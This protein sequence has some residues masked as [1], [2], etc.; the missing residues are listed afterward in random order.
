[1]LL[2]HSLHFIKLYLM[3]QELV[4]M[5]DHVIETLHQD[6]PEIELTTRKTIH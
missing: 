6:H 3:T 5:L 4:D 1:M 2:K